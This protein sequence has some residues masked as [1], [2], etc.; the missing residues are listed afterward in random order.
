L[1]VSDVVDVTTTVVPVA[2]P[3]D[4]VPNTND[5]TK[6]APSPRVSKCLPATVTVAPPVDVPVV[7]V[8]DVTL[9]AG[10]TKLNAFANVPVFDPAATVWWTVAGTVPAT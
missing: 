2:M 8:T 5:V 4:T 10:V 3:V 6:D 7:G 1:T 9:G